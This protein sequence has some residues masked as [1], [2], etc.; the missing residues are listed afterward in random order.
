MFVSDSVIKFDFAILIAGF[1][2][3]STKHADLYTQQVTIPTLHV[4]GDT[5]KVIGKGQLG[6]R[7]PKHYI[8]Q[9][10]EPIM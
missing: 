2:S 4:Y 10:L 9:S 5:D 1:K 3:R 8:Q 7:H 6:V